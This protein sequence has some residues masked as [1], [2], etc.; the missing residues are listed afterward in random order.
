MAKRVFELAREIGVTSKTVLEKCRAEG[1]DIKNHMSTV[2]A[3]LEATLREWF[4][5]AVE[6]TAVETS[7][8]VDLERARKEAARQRRR[9]KKRAAEEA[10]E[11]PPEPAEAEL[12]QTPEAE[13]AAEPSEPPAGEPESPVEAAVAEAPEA[14]EA[15]PDEDEVT[16]EAESAE[17]ESDERPVEAPPAEEGEQPEEE[18]E[19]N[20][21]VMPAGPKVVPKPA[22][23]QGPRVVRMERPE[24]T[25][26]PRRRTPPPRGPR[27]VPSG[28]PDRTRRGREDDQRRKR[29]RRSPRRR[30]GGRSADS[31]EKL[32]EWRNQDLMERQERLAAAS[33]GLRRH[34]TRVGN[35]GGSGGPAVQAGTVEIEEPITVKSLSAAT[36]LKAGLIIKKLMAE[37]IMATVNQGVDRALAESV[38]AEY[39]IELVVKEAKTAEQELMERIDRR[40]K[41]AT[42]ARPPVVTFL[43]HVDHGKTSLLDY[44]RKTGVAGGEAGGITQHIGASRYELEGG[45]RVVFLDTPGHEAFTAMRARGANMTDVVVLVVAA[46]DGVMPQ[47]IEAISHA[48]AAQVPIV[49]A[50]NKIDVPNANPQRA[51]AQLAE[52]GLQPREWGGDTEVIQTSAETGAGIDTLVETLS[53]EA[54]L[55]ELAAETG[56][57]AGGFVI[58]AE[59]DPGRGVLARLLVRNGTLRTGDV[60]LAGGGYGRVRQMIDDRGKQVEEAGPSTAVEV[61]GLDEVPDAGDRFYAVASQDEARAVA[62]DR[63]QRSRAESLAA[64]RVSVESLLAQM[65]GEETQELK[66]VVKADVQGSVEALVASL[67]KL[68]TDEAPLSVLHAGVGGVTTGDVTLAE[69]SG[70]LI[71]AFSVVAGAP[72]RQLADEKDVDIRQYRVIYDVIEDVRRALAEGLAPEIRTETL[73]RAEV[74]EV[75]KVSRVGT[76]AG[77]FVHDGVAARNAKVRVT[78]NDVIVVDERDVASLKRFKDDAR[79]VR[80][81]MECGVRI[82]GFDD[83]KEGD[84]LEFYRQVEVAR[85]L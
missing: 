15:P 14:P 75:F 83:V 33:G 13:P 2:S 18:P 78:R 47:T 64:N 19:A 28:E 58:E 16:S 36:G 34:R 46:D 5:E 12:Q 10:A 48:K 23:L 57:P 7:E 8:H 4:S 71:I 72:A 39:D 60:L 31:G 20:E 52:Q 26:A 79:E 54:E 6:G 82:A 55:L 35:K 25:P 77:C 37:G 24:S 11:N 38:A 59:V 69:A 40:E 74:R 53:L 51:L 84:M 50:L 43:G 49:V 32:K 45:R 30:S 65:G 1:L 80:A 85:T 42:E 73:G 27:V 81:G 76:V 29:K 70:A 9:R 22:T 21:S 17:V 68:A 61:A 41:G 44:I 56:A 67:E 62:E 63:R 3:G 66:L